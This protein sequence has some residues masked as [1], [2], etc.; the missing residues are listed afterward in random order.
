M[1]FSD[2][3]GIH[4][5]LVFCGILIGFG[6]GV[7]FALKFGDGKKKVERIKTLTAILR[8]ITALL[9][10]GGIIWCFFYLIKG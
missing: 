7:W 4:W 5:L 9:I 10:A 8:I 1:V 3:S 2:L 6:I